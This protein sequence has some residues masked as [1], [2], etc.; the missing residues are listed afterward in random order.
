MRRL[1]IVMLVITV[2]ATACASGT[3]RRVSKAPVS[4]TAKGAPTSSGGSIDWHACGS[5]DCA[6]LAVPLVAGKPARGTIS[7][8][9]ARHR[10]TGERIGALLTN[11]GGP[12]TAG[13]W[14]AQQA[15]QVFP[16][17]IL[18]HFDIVA[19]DPRGT[20]RSTAVDCTSKLD[21]F[22]SVDRTP[23]NAMEV[24]AN[25]SAAQRL[26]N[27]CAAH[28]GRILP[29][30]SS[31]ASAADMESIRRAL[32]DKQISYIGFSYGTYLGTLYANAY[33]SHVRAMVLDGAIDPALSSDA[34]GE[35][36]A[37]GFEQSL[38]A[39][40]A[41]CSKRPS[42]AFHSGGKSATAF[43]RLMRQIDAEP[44]YA[45]LHGETRSLGPGEADVGVAE[46]MYGGRSTWT[47]LASALAAAARGE[48][49]KLLALSDDYT[50]RTTGGT[51]SNQT[52]A[53]YATGCLDSPMPPNV[54]AVQ[55]E[56]DR[57]SRLAP[58]FGASTIWLGLPCVYWRAASKAKPTALAARGAPPILVLGTTHDPATP[59]AWATS[60][61]RELQSGHLVALNDE[62]HTA[63]ARGSTCIDRVVHAYLLHLTVPKAGTTCT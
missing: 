43:D 3:A 22:W 21:F 30:L 17:T 60:L 8:A 9:L 37:V 63:Y 14:I 19:W 2:G 54:A 50:E 38:D 34:A 5:V 15:E 47:K 46:A 41:D 32:G 62:G 42:C 18:Q 33:P 58:H 35:Q 13:L 56:A 59:F 52:G 20:G 57:A 61:A 48:G 31:Q 27:D 49:A 28:S 11:P 36:Q 12:G 4:S 40:L 51:Y 23:D 24:A 39:F 53:F 16:A 6:T 1:L 29:Y 55:Q 7:L 45:K 25:A 10:A 26:A 44:V